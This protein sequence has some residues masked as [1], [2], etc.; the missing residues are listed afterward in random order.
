LTV[1]KQEGGS[2]ID[3]TAA[4][5]YALTLFVK[6]NFMGVGM[7]SN[8][9]SSLI[10]SLLST[11]GALGLVGFLVAYFKLLSNADPN[12]PELKWAGLAFFICLAASAPDYDAPWIWVFLAFVVRM[13]HSKVDLSE[14]NI[15]LHSAIQIRRP[16]EDD[17]GGRPRPRFE[18]SS[19]C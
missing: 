2:F 10:P 3:R 12:H 16:C 11:V 17:Q 1:N 6:T 13:R 5:T 9:P 18:H 19:G 8:R 14:Q 4:D 15:K 7:G